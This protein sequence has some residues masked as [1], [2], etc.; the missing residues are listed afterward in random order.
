MSQREA[1]LWNQG[2]CGHL[3]MGAGCSHRERL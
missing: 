1:F 2:G 3:R